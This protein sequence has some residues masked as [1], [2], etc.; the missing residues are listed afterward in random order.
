MS[1]KKNKTAPSTSRKPNCLTAVGNGALDV[2]KKPQKKQ[3]GASTFLNPN[4]LTAVGDGALDV[5]QNRSDFYFTSDLFHRKRSPF[6]K[7]EG[8][9]GQNF[10]KLFHS[11]RGRALNVCLFTTVGGGVIY[12]CRGR[13]PR[14]PETKKQP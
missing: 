10:G 4:C 1:R 13:R 14:R 2:P 3:D 6:P 7:G 12:R 5:P 9:S 8:K 11:R